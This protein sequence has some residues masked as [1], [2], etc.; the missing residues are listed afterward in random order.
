MNEFVLHDIETPMVIIFMIMSMV[1]AIIHTKIFEILFGLHLN[2][3]LF[4]VVNPALIGIVT[5]IDKRFSLFAF[6]LLC[7]SVFL[8]AFIGMIYAGVKTS[9]KGLAVMDAYNKKH[10]KKPITWRQKMLIILAGLFFIISFIFFGIEAILLL[11]LLIPYFR[12]VFPGNETRFFNLQNSLPTSTIR[13]L[14]MG[15]AEI[16]GKLEMIN[17]IQSPIGKKECIGFQHKIA[18]IS[19]DDD[20]KERFSTIFSEIDCNPFYIV[21]DTGKIEVNPEK[22]EM[23]WVKEDGQ[24]RRD[25]KLHTEYLLNPDEKMLIIGEAGVK[26]NNQ[27]VFKYENIKKVFAIS[28]SVSIT[29][30]NTYKPLLNSFIGFSCVFA[31]LTSIILITP[32]K[33]SGNKIIIEKPKF[34]SNF[35]SDKDDED[36]IPSD[37]TKQI[38]IQ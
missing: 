27:P 10:N 14:A 33:I 29:N 11:F 25:G 34:Q 20:G 18:N 31:F 6:L 7:F 9:K 19:L 28:P 26:E 23:I 16:E 30:Y 24:Y 2:K 5:W 1:L 4:F 38:E 12:W 36:N 32:M 17:P 35:F 8:V 21:D 3:W 13:S 15:I 22:L 37:S